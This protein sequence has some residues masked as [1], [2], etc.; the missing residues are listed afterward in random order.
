MKLRIFCW[1]SV[2]F[3]TEG[4]RLTVTPVLSED[5]RSLL[6]SAR[7]VRQPQGRLVDLLSVSV[8]KDPSSILPFPIRPPPTKGVVEIVSATRTPP[9]AKPVLDLTLVD[10]QRLVLLHPDSAS[11][12]LGR[13]DDAFERSPQRR[14]GQGLQRDAR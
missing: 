9:L 10:D 6:A 8:E 2:R 13:G 5:P 1:R 4:P 3:A 7:V 11:L 14:A 12:V